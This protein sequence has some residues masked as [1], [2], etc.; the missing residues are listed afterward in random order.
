MNR[1]TRRPAARAQAC[2]RTPGDEPVNL[3]VTGAMLRSVRVVRTEQGYG[4][5]TVTIGFARDEEAQKASYVQKRRV[6]LGVTPE[7][8]AELAKMV[9]AAIGGSEGATI[10]IS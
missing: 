5:G 10:A 8:R 2:P 4:S 3:T 6:F 7:E 1:A 9:S